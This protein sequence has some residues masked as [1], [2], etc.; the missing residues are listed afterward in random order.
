MSELPALLTKKHTW[1]AWS[2]PAGW[3]VHNESPSLAEH[4]KKTN[5][6][7]D[8]H[9]LNRLDRD[10][11][12]IVIVSES[13][14]AIPALQK[15]WQADDTKKIYVGIHRRPRDFSMWERVW[16]EPL[17]DRAEGRKNPQGLSR[18]RLPCETR[19]I[20]VEETEHLVLSVLVLGT[21]RQ[22]QIRKHS[23]LHRMELAGDT[24]YGDPKYFEK[25]SKHLSPLRLGLHAAFLKWSPE[26]TP[27]VVFSPLPD[28]FTTV[29]PNAHT[30]VQSAIETL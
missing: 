3:T 22:H 13:A 23:V 7:A 24:R 12:G 17:T 21:G 1:Q 11:S 6:K 14:A 16:T 18:E 25:L 15:V 27:V 4:L 5:P 10:T 26:G 28:F 29:F 20:P 19:L 9:F 2:K 8:F 30:K